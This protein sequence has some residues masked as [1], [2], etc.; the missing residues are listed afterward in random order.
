MAIIDGLQATIAS[1]GHELPELDDEECASTEPRV[2]TKYVEVTSGS[3]FS[4]KVVVHSTFQWSSDL[5]VRFLV[6]GNIVKSTGF[7][8]KGDQEQEVSHVRV[9]R[10]QDKDIRKTLIF[11]DVELV[12]NDHPAATEINAAQTAKIGTISVK[13]FRC[14]RTGEHR[15]SPSTASLPSQLQIP[16][17]ALKGKAVSN[18]TIFGP[19]QLW[20]ASKLFNYKLLDGDDS[21][22][23]V[24]NF[25]YRSKK[26][27]QDLHIIPRTPSP[28]LPEQGPNPLPNEEIQKL[29]ERVREGRLA[30]RILKKQSGVK[31]ESSEECTS[32]AADQRPRKTSDFR[33][34]DA[35]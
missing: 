14:Y 10:A 6:D 29:E 21:P 30:E 22:I 32:S 9:G 26:A 18:S 13:A 2:A 1:E 19:E 8:R 33:H 5:H 20:S 35:R 3:S 12:D 34:I 23:A 17:K 11:A 16:E 4:M 31:R 25:K 7:T 15:G 28:D 27:L 24:F